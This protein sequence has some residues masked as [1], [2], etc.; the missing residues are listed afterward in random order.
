MALTSIARAIGELRGIQYSGRPNRLDYLG[1]N[2]EQRVVVQGDSKGKLIRT[3]VADCM[4]EVRSGYKGEAMLTFAGRFSATVNPG[5]EQGRPRPSEFL[6][7]TPDMPPDMEP[8][9]VS[10]ADVDITTQ[11]RWLKGENEKLITHIRYNGINLEYICLLKER[12]ERG[13]E[14]QDFCSTDK[15]REKRALTEEELRNLAEQEIKGMIFQLLVAPLYF[16]SKNT[17][18]T[19]P[20]FKALLDALFEG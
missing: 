8:L 7:S 10:C 18:G 4:G 3:E 15:K 14:F 19:G 17:E 5:G 13:L 1:Y 12:K 20:L 6:G 9:R 16:A 11:S 2:S